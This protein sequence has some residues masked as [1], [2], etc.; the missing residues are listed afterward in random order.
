MASSSAEV[1]YLDATA[2]AEQRHNCPEVA[3]HPVHVSSALAAAVMKVSTSAGWLAWSSAGRSSRDGP[4]L[5]QTRRS[6]A[7]ASVP[8]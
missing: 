2:G 8:V 3:D 6:F 5:R 7:R 4:A 1:G